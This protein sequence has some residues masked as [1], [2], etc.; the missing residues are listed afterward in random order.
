MIFAAVVIYFL[1]VV[2]K[3]LAQKERLLSFDD[4]NMNETYK[5]KFFRL[6]DL[7]YH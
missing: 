6:E 4:A 2:V 5:K 7:P 3:R 1:I